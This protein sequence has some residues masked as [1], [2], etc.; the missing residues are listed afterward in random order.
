MIGGG[1]LG[2]SDVGGGYGGLQNKEYWQQ[3]KQ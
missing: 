1:G 2:D 3:R